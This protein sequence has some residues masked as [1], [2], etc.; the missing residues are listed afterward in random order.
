MSNDPFAGHLAKLA[1]AAEP[2][3][4][5]SD[6]Y[7]A[8]E[9]AAEECVLARVSTIRIIG[10]LP[11]HLPELSPAERRKRMVCMLR[12]WSQGCIHAYDEAL[13]ADVL[14]RRSPNR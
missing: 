3:D 2:I 4:T 13:F 14:N 9:R 1:A 5:L 6:G 12:L 7:T 11:R 10:G 8:W